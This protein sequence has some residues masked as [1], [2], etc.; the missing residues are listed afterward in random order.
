MSVFLRK[1]KW[2]FATECWGLFLGVGGLLSRW[3]QMSLPLKGRFL[4]SLLT[5]AKDSVCKCEVYNSGTKSRSNIIVH[6]SHT[7]SVELCV[8]KLDRTSAGAHSQKW[9]SLLSAHCTRTGCWESQVLMQLTAVRVCSS[10]ESHQAHD[11]CVRLARNWSTGK[12]Q[13]LL[14]S[15]HS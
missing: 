3:C 9:N 6:T 14:F 11:A 5:P 4:P 8:I 10:V 15:G 12:L 13:W 2:S 7:C 1:E